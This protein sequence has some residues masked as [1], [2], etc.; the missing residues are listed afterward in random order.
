[1]N[2]PRVDL[3]TALE[4]HRVGRLAEA[5]AMY[6]RALS[7]NPDDA[8]AL[9]LL[10]VILHQNKRSAEGAPLIQRA[11]ELQPNI[12]SYHNNLGEVLRELDRCDE[13]IACFKRALQLKPAY[14]EAYNN[15]GGEY[16]RLAR[17]GDSISCLRKCIGLA[18]NDPDAHWNL[19]VALLLTGDWQEGWGEFEW[20]LRRKE[21]PGRVYPKPLWNGQPLIGKT[22][23]LWSEQGFGDMIQFFRYVAEARRFGGRI[24]VDVQPPLV[25]LLTAQNSADGV[26]A[27]GAA[28][29]AFDYHA[30]LMSMPRI[31]KT[32]LQTVPQH[33]PYIRASADRARYWAERLSESPHRKI[34]IAWAGRPEHPNDRRRSIPADLLAAL[35]TIPDTTFVTIQPR[36]ANAPAPTGIPL[37]DFGP[38]LTDFADTAGLMSQL[39]LIISVDTSVAHLAG[40]MGRTVW[41]LLPFS[42][43]WRWLMQREDSPWYP[44]M[45]VFRQRKLGDWEGVIAR[46]VAELKNLDPG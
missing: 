7:L 29:P 40:A 26:Y 6:R 38:E 17:M 16:G 43:D 33:I 9:H 1:V 21:S 35:G 19:S 13:A 39:K 3:Y 27:A 37:M 28:L 23:L 34:G 25:P 31:M 20:R 30:A 12:A 22:L 8:S 24:I 45:R 46:V 18:P 15:M 36:P 14:P 10:G 11:I 42:P 2:T 5:E 4:L 41:L 44:T 32:T